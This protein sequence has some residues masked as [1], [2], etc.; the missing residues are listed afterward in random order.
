MLGHTPES[1]M[2]ESFF[3]FVHEAERA[4]VYS[5]LSQGQ[6]AE[7]LGQSRSLIDT[8]EPYPVPQGTDFN[9]ILKNHKM[10]NFDKKNLKSSS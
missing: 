8:G 4:E 7:A 5:K 6:A 1:I 2:N 10:K 9:L 3:Q